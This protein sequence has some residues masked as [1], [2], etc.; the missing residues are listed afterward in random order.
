MPEPIMKSENGY[1]KAKATAAKLGGKVTDDFK[2]E[3]MPEDWLSA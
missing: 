2:E 1:E 3:D